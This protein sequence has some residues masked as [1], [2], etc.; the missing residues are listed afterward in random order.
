MAKCVVCL[1]VF[2][3]ILETSKSFFERNVPFTQYSAY[4]NVSSAAKFETDTTAEITKL[5]TARYIAVTELNP[6]DPQATWALH[7]T[8]NSRL[9]FANCCSR[10][11]NFANQLA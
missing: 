6:I 1:D 8:Y 2:S 5:E 3:S 7:F 10:L 11:L 9:C 4:K